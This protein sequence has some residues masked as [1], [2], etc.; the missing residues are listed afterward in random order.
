MKIVSWNCNGGF[1]K[2]TDY[3]DEIDADI[4]IIQECENPKPSTKA[5]L[6][7]AG[8]YLW[9]GENKNRGL[10]IFSRNGNR[11]QALDWQGEYTLNVPSDQSKIRNHG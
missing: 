2:K 11:I 4:L 10:G 3:V 5:Y 1:R 7:W 6:Q 8:D 9:V